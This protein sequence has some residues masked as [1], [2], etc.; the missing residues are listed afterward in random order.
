MVVRLPPR[1]FRIRGKS[2]SKRSEKFSFFSNQ[3]PHT[4]RIWVSSR[5]LTTCR[6]LVRTSIVQNLMNRL[7]MSCE[8]ST[9]RTRAN[10][11]PW[12]SGAWSSDDFPPMPSIFK[13]TI[14]FVA[15]RSIGQQSFNAIGLILGATSIESATTSESAMITSRYCSRRMTPFKSVARFWYSNF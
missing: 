8:F 7:G 3:E 5:R 14:P 4:L 15:S 9:D 10:A 6:P 2:C 1:D 13:G 11:F 12:I